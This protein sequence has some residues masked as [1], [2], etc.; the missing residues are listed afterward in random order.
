LFLGRKAQK[1]S[2]VVMHLIEVQSEGYETKQLITKLG[3][4]DP[5][6]QRCEQKIN[7][8]EGGWDG[9]CTSRRRNAERGRQKVEFRHRTGSKTWAVVLRPFSRIKKKPKSS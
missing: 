7:G 9:G 1:K 5:A 6:A 2:Y 3:G 8:S 4:G